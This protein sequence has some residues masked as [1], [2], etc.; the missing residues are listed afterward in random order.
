GRGTSAY[1]EPRTPLEG[2]MA[3]IWTEVLGLDRVGAFDNFFELGGHSLLAAQ[4]IARLRER[5][6]IA[7]RLRDLFERPVLADLVAHLEAEHAAEA[8][9][10]APVLISDEEFERQLDAMSTEELEAAL[11]EMTA[12]AQAHDDGERHD[13]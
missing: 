6:G 3:E 13:G 4:L 5:H 11:R 1:V 12:Q 2:A 7:L 9:D 10:A 8:H